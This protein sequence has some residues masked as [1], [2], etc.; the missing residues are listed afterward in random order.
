[1][2]IIGFYISNLYLNIPLYYK[3]YNPF[4]SFFIS[5]ITYSYITTPRTLYLGIS[6]PVPKLLA[7][8]F[9]RAEKNTHIYPCVFSLYSILFFGFP[10]D[11]LHPNLPD[12]CHFQT[13][14]DRIFKFT[15]IC[16]GVALTQNPEGID[17]LPVICHF[18][19]VSA[20]N[21]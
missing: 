20:D 7:H 16:R 18:L 8:A 3:Y 19:C 6:M 21:G 9:F 13:F 1:M 5:A 12:T 15:H 17:L 11:F 2:R 14:S 10:R 4:V